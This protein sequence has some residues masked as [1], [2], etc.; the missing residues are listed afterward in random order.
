M[1]DELIKVLI[2][3]C[4]IFVAVWAKDINDTLNRCEQMI[5]HIQEI[6]EN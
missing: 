2:I 5:T 3:L 1:L 6:V 4:L